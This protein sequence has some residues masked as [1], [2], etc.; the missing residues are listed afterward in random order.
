MRSRQQGC[1]GKGY[2]HLD[3]MSGAQFV[4]VQGAKD[5]LHPDPSNV[6]HLRPVV[7]TIFWLFQELDFKVLF[8]SRQ[9]LKS[10]LP[11]C[12][13]ERIL[14]LNFKMVII[15]VI[16]SITCLNLALTPRSKL[17]Y[18]FNAQSTMMVISIWRSKLAGHNIYGIQ[19]QQMNTSIFKLT[20]PPYSLWMSLCP[21]PTGITTLM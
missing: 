20:T 6:I 11:W 10:Y 4:E 21:R 2:L 17:V 18:C 19:I 8:I 1:P 12:K 16:S 14:P 3:M 7:E 5:V 15:F 9:H 13:S